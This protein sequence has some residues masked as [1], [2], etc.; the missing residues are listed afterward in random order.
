MLKQG[1]VERVQEYPSKYKWPNGKQKDSM[2][3]M[4][5]DNIRYS[6]KNVKPPA[7][8]SYVQFEATQQGEYWNADPSTIKNIEAPAAQRSV[9]PSTTMSTQL[10]S[11]NLRDASIH[12]QSSRKDALELVKML[13]AKDMIDFGKAKAAQKIEIVEIYLDNYT[14]RFVEDIKRLAP[15]EHASPIDAE[16]PESVTV[17]AKPPRKPKEPAVEFDEDIPFKL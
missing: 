15:P 5:V 14:S 6:T 11:T 13:L 16:M 1:F 9:A 2:W 8:G 17:L 12:Y 10:G 3:A 4:L 7:E